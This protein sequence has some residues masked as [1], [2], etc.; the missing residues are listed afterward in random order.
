MQPIG[1]SKKNAGQVIV[2]QSIFIKY[3]EIQYNYRDT[4]QEKYTKMYLIA[5]LI[6]YYCFLT[7]Y[8]M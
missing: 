7:N 5:H 2:I 1:P 8:I 6:T 4:Y 3:V